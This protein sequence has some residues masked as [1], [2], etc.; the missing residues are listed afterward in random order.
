VVPFGSAAVQHAY[1]AIAGEYGATFADE[2]EVNEFDRGIVDAAIARVPRGGIVL[3][4]G[5]GPAQVSRRVDTAGGAAIGID[6][7]PA[8]LAIARRHAPTLP[9]TCGDVLAL[10]YRR[11][12]AAATIAWYSLH[13]LPRLLMPMALSEM[14]R[15]LRP[16]GTALIATH[17][18]QGEEMIKQ[19]RSDG[20]ETVTITYY[21]A[22]EL[23]VLAEEHGLAP[24]E[25]QERPPLDH[26]HQVRKLYLTASAT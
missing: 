19:R 25:L 22:E 5:C 18:G 16:G 12:I 23:V 6:L 3:D 1:E 2:L 14:R 21:E 17:A 26:E 10:P 20:W 13:N 8:M 4:V 24:V 11:D 9:L 15:V 7:T